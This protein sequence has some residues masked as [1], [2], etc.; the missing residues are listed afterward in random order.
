MAGRPSARPRSYPT[1]PLRAQFC[2]RVS[3]GSGARQS[4]ATRSLDQFEL[5]LA[6]CGSGPSVGIGTLRR[7]PSGSA[8]AGGFWENATG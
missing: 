5:S 2:E 3:S 8:T 7:R 1:R 4:A 6:G